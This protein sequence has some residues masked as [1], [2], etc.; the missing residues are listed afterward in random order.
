[1]R[2]TPHLSTYQITHHAL[3]HG[4]THSSRTINYRSQSLH[5]SSRTIPIDLIR[6]YTSKNKNKTIIITHYYINIRKL[7]IEYSLCDTLW[8]IL[9][10][11]EFV[12]VG[13]TIGLICFCALEICFFIMK[14][15]S[16]DNHS[17]NVMCFGAILATGS[18]CIFCAK[19]I[20]KSI[21]VA[22]YFQQ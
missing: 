9:S 2:F 17:F 5:T 4:M 14:I 13:T 21:T 11:S 10:V 6:I 12:I 8:T 22:P 3:L 1:M 15:Y 7:F 20:V 16:I 19:V 18:K